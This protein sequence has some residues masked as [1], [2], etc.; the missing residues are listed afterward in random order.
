MNTETETIAP[1]RT[2][3]QR[4]DQWLSVHVPTV[5]EQ[6]NPPA[7]EAEIEAAEE[8]L[9]IRLPAELRESLACHNGLVG[10]AALLPEQSPLSAAS[11]AGHWQLCMEI[12][13]DVEG[14]DAKPWDEEPWWHPL[15][16]PWADSASGDA[17]VFD[18]RPGPAAGRLGWA[19]H[20][21]CG[22]FSDTWPSLAALLHD[23]ARALHEGGDV[24]GLRPYLL[25]DGDLWWDGDEP[26]E[27]TGLSLRRAPVGVG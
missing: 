24:R 19:V 16:I 25:E 12:A 21:G 7:D 4:I 18:L 20:D 14:F 22:D 11:L 17:H 15:W 9:G 5:L 27:I 23:V 13:Q 6:L 2:S 10:G 3:W 1:V 8:V 26:R